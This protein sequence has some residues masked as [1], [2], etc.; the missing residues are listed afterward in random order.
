MSNEWPKH[1]PVTN[2]EICQN[3]WNNQ[4]EETKYCMGCTGGDCDCLC[5]S[6]ETYAQEERRRVSSCRKDRKK[7]MKE[8]LE[9]ESNPLRGF[10]PNFK[11]KVRGRRLPA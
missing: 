4:H 3:C 2:R 8:A 10:N 7:L 11:E 5:R 1:D 9:S 6:E